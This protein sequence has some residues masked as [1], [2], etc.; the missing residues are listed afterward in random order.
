MKIA[1]DTEIGETLMCEICGHT[2]GSKASHDYHYES[3][4]MNVTYECDICGEVYV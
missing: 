1:H 3:K 4:H 2:T